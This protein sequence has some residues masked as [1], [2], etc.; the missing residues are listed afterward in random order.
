MSRS[1]KMHT[2]SN[3][4]ATRS[5]DHPD[6]HARNNKVV[7]GRVTDGEGCTSSRRDHQ[8]AHTYR[9]LMEPVGFTCSHLRRIL[10]PRLWC[11]LMLTSSTRGVALLGELPGATSDGC[12]GGAMVWH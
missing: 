2:P 3:S 4:C 1:L 12:A 5:S 11:G 8:V 7:R 6:P 9:S 10:M